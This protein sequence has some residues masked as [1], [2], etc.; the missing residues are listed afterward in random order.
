MGVVV[1]MA[2][3]SDSSD[4]EQASRVSGQEVAQSTKEEEKNKENVLAAGILG[5]LSPAVRHVDDKVA[6][7]R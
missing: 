4:S 2:D 6:E 5:V 3:V 1:N 7:V